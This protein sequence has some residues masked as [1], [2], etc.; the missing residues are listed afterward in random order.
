M[1]GF[2]PLALETPSAKTHPH[3]FVHGPLMQAQRVGFGA[4]GRGRP[5]RAF[6]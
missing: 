4:A 1:K 6:Q 3:R 2:P 5:D